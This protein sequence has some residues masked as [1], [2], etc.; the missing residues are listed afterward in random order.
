MVTKCFFFNK[1]FTA[2]LLNLLFVAINFPYI[3]WKVFLFEY[4]SCV[5]LVY[6]NIF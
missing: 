4:M 5:M 3:T 2:F 6:Y 1:I